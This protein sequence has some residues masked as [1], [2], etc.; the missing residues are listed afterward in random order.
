[1][2]LDFK[3]AFVSLSIFTYLS[4]SSIFAAEKQSG[5]NPPLSLSLALKEYQVFHAK[6]IRKEWFRLFCDQYDILQREELW[7]LA[8]KTKNYS[9][10]S[11]LAAL[12]FEGDLLIVFN[13]KTTALETYDIASQELQRINNLCLKNSDEFDSIMPVA[14]GYMVY[15]IKYSDLKTK[16][17]GYTFSWREER[18]RLFLFSL[19]DG[20]IIQLSDDQYLYSY[21]GN[22]KRPGQ[23]F[24]INLIDDKGNLYIHS[25]LK[26]QEK[27]DSEP[28]FK[29]YGPPKTRVWRYNIE[30]GKKEFLYT[31]PY[32]LTDLTFNSEGQLTFAETCPIRGDENYYEV[33]KDLRLTSVFSATKESS[34]DFKGLVA[35]PYHKAMVLLDRRF[36][37][38]RIPILYQWGSGL[39]TYKYLLTQEQINHLKSDVKSAVIDPEKPDQLLYLATE[40]DKKR[41][42][43]HGNNDLLCIR[44][45]NEKTNLRKGSGGLAFSSNLQRVIVTPGEWEGSNKLTVYDID[46]DNNDITPVFSHEL[47]KPLSCARKFSETVFVEIPAMDGTIMPGYLTLPKGI[48]RGGCLNL[49]VF[50]YIHG[51]PHKRDKLRFDPTI[52]FLASRKMALF[53][54]NY[55]GSTGF[56]KAYENAS[57]GRW[58]KVVKYVHDARDW[59][60]KEKIAHPEKIAIGG[61]SFG[62]YVA[63]ASLQDHPLDYQCGIALNGIYNLPLELGRESQSEDTDFDIARQF[64]GIFGNRTPEV[65]RFL[66]RLSPALNEA[67]ILTPL[68]LLHATADTICPLEQAESLVKNHPEMP[69]MYGHFKDEQHNLE[70]TEHRLAQ[71]ALTE[72]FLSKYLG[73]FSEPLED[74]LKIKTFKWKKVTV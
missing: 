71:A 21:L 16:S 15:K 45:L 46:R 39:P 50:M 6:E 28:L 22:V 60:V 43:V 56:G 1:M 2:K 19:G 5:E 66:E 23:R 48:S 26:A 9:E 17:G 74:V 35:F 27:Q 29:A 67:K 64:S 18:D 57:D 20:K 10:L 14:P 32:N 49:P 73:T 70:K 4:L 34:S 25:A 68:L 3:T 11:A 55:P 30:S 72:W 12:S 59:L 36:T 37:D 40:Y 54:V 42:E 33:D 8:R 38:K 13:P 41:F 44:K 62:A 52:H 65:D 24:L 53:Q 63:V 51:G 69:V 61:G 47:H 31:L 7:P 58:D